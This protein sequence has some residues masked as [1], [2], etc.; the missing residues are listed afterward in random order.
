MTVYLKAF[1]TIHYLKQLFVK[2]ILQ[3]NGGF[4]IYL[5]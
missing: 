4:L 1:F 3:P 2:V 5:N